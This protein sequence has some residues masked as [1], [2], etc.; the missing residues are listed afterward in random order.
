MSHLRITLVALAAVAALQPISALA[1]RTGQQRPPV[2]QQQ[3]QQQQ[4]QHVQMMAQMQE[5][6]QRMNQL[7]E[8]AHKLAQQAQLQVQDRARMTERERLMLRTSESFEQHAKQ[9]SVV[10]ERTQDMIRSRDFQ[11]D[12]EMQRDMDRLREHL[13]TMATQLDESLQLM[14]RLRLRARSLAAQ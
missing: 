8:R 2:S 6:V 14:E 3:A 1:Q 7:Q 13:N 10:A 9:L 5:T 4:Q 11:R 12:Q